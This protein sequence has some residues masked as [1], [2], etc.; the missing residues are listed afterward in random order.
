MPDP[1]LRFRFSVFDIEPAASEFRKRGIR[2]RL[3]GKPFEVLVY[4]L[5]RPGELVTRQQL[6]NHLWPND[7][8][9]EFENGLNNAISRLRSALGDSAGVPR[10]IETVPRRGYRFVAPVERVARPIGTHT[11]L[12]G[13]LPTSHA[14]HSVGVLPFLTPSGAS[15][16][17]EY[18][19]FGMFDA[20]IAELARIGSLRVISQTSVLR[21]KDDRPALR[22]IAAELGVGAIVEGSIVRESHRTRIS[23]QLIDAATDT[24]LWSELYR[25]DAASALAEHADLARLVA[26]EIADRLTGATASAPETTPAAAAA[27][28]RVREAYLRGRYFL[29][30]GTEAGRARESFEAALSVDPDDAL[31]HAGLADYYLLTD[32]QPPHVVMAKARTHAERALALNPALADAHVSLGFLHYHGDWNWAAAERAFDRALALSPSHAQAYRWRSKYL[33]AMCRHAE[34]ST[35]VT[36]AIELDPLSL[37][38]L[39]SAGQVWFHAREYDRVLEVAARMLDLHP[40]AMPGLEHVAAVSVLRQDFARAR[41][42]I[43]QATAAHGRDPLPLMLLAQ[44]QGALDE[45]A[46]WAATMVELDRLRSA[47]R[48]PPF[49]MAIACLGGGDRDQALDWLERGYE[50]RDSY[51]VMLRVSPWMDPLRALPRFRTLVERMGFPVTA[52]A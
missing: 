7:T 18:L 51:L 46:A 30:H 6:Q 35:G 15:A 42:T 41:S 2:V 39:D 37:A 5:E 25:R 49:F 28:P 17:E 4:L 44:L 47:G 16:D 21:Y 50:S 48:V 27:D 38:A 26:R 11:R 20:V 31:S 24:H 23:V 3:Q 1:T 45:R 36:R 8:F 19:A 33:A 13:R 14:E 32:L 34:A 9:V 22:E 40:A 52:R 29:S 43:D 10:F 12:A